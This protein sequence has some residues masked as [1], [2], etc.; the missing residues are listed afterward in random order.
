MPPTA[1]RWPGPPT[2]RLETRSAVSRSVNWLI[3]S[4]IS[5]ILG[6]VGAASVELNRRVVEATR[7]ICAEDLAALAERNWRAQLRAAYRQDMAMA[8]MGC[9]GGRG[10]GTGRSRRV[11]RAG[12]SFDKQPRIEHPEVFRACPCRW[13]SLDA[14]RWDRSGAGDWLG[15][16]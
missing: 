1:N 8:V 12:F 13:W 3:W 11:S 4:T 14:R 15:Y 7:S 6:L 9:E 10:A 5:A 16:L 2:L